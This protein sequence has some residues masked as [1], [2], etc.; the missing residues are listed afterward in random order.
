MLNLTH[1]INTEDRMQQKLKLFGQK[2]CNNAN[3]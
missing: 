1:L 3:R 2:G